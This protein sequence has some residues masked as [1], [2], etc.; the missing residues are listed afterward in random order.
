MY[1]SSKIKYVMVKFRRGCLLKPPSPDPIGL[2]HY[3][4]NST[5]CSRSALEH[6]GCYN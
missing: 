1:Y 3:A 6:Y 4:L 5:A 2:I